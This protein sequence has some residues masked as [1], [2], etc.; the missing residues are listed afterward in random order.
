VK[1][2][3]F[4]GMNRTATKA[5]HELF[6]ASGYKSFHYSC[7]DAMTGEPIILASEM[8]QN[9]DSY[10]HVLNRME[11]AQVYSDMFWHREDEWID[12]VKMYRELYAQFPDAYFILQTRDMYSWLLSKK[13]HKD[14]DY[15]QRCMQY[16]NLDMDQMIDWFES[17][18]NEHESNV[19]S[20]FKN[21][22]NFLE[23]DIDKDNI[24][25]F[26]D[27][28]KPSFFLKEKDWGRHD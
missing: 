15:I 16:H 27:F 5:F 23:Y 4:I 22:P 25:K 3:F 11:K 12:G 13:N 28:L 1:K 19:R 20:Y 26:I 17:D 14:G 10:K 2:V 7:A 6:V 9:L 21:N 8:K 24:T 18:R